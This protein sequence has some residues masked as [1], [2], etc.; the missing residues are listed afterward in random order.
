MAIPV[1]LKGF[2]GQKIEFYPGLIAGPKL[3]IDGQEPPVDPHRGGMIL[4]RSDGK[5]INATW[6]SQA[7]GMD[8]AQLVIDGKAVPL[9]QPL[10]WYHYLWAGWTVGLAA[11]GGIL[12][13][14]IGVVVT[15]TNV[16]VFRT[17]LKTPLK[18]LLTGIIT[19]VGFV[20]YFIGAM[21]LLP[22]LQK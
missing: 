10:K 14:V 6:K 3:L 11:F 2:E 7:F 13:A 16:R 19:A 12:G 9:A 17:G 18:Y 22:V 15:W 8:V 20:L 1:K 21:L 4:T 5:T